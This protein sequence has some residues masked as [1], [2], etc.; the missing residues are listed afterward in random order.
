MYNED[1]RRPGRFWKAG[2]EDIRLEGW[3][4]AVVVGVYKLHSCGF[5]NRVPFKLWLL[6]TCYESI[7]L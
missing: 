2:G 6:T 5:D 1:E 4:E 3:W 7:R